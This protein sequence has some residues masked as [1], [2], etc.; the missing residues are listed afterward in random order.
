MRDSRDGLDESVAFVELV[1]YIDQC[2][3]E[4]THVFKLSELSSLYVQRLDDLGIE[5]TINRAR[6]KKALLEHYNGALQEKSHGKNTILVFGEA[7]SNLLKDALK[8]DFS[9][10]GKT[11]ARA[12]AIIRKDIFNH[13]SFNFSGCLPINC[14]SSYLPCS[15]MSLISMIL[16]GVDI[17]AKQMAKAINVKLKYLIDLHAWCHHVHGLLCYTICRTE[18][19]PLFHRRWML[20]GTEL[21]RIILQFEE[22]FLTSQDPDDPKNVQN[23]KPGRAAQKTFQRQVNN[24]CVIVR[25]IGNP[26]LDDF[27][28][29]VPIGS[30][31]CA[32]VSVIE[33]IKKLAEIG[34]DKYTKYVN[35]VIKN[36][37]RSIQDPIKKNSL[38]LFQKNLKKTTSKKGKKIALLQSNLN[39]FA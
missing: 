31:D 16:N 13:G 1:K 14:Q 2:V 30:R 29:L 28:E 27:S 4:G 26:F 9:E 21:S 24:L 20:S 5:K 3:N 32:D 22:Q 34:K 36:R 6:L 37:T 23:H 7:I 11:R 15:L 8:R 17:K 12:A 38:P 35:E 25:R 19:A 39:L 18:V 33:T 10:E